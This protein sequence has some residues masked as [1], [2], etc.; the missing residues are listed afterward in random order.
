MKKAL[1][2]GGS[3]VTGLGIVT[4]IGLLVKRAMRKRAEKKAGTPPAV[5][6]TP[7]TE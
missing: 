4:G 5:E 6:P 3:I 1:W 7:A 2:I